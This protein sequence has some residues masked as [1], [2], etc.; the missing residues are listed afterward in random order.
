MEDIRKKQRFYLRLIG[1]TWIVFILAVIGLLL[2]PLSFDQKL[3]ILVVLV[4]VQLGIF[5]WISPRIFYYNQIYG[6]MRLKD[7][8]A[9]SIRTKQDL[10]GKSF[11][12]RLDAERFKPFKDYGSYVLFYRTTKDK[13]D[14]A[15]RRTMLEVITII[16]NDAI[17][18]DDAK[19]VSAVNDV[20]DMAM[21][22]KIRYKNHSIIQIKAGNYKDKKRI[23][24]A[25]QVVFETHK[26]HRISMINV[27]YDSAHDRAYF[28]HGKNYAPNAYYAYVVELCKTLA[29][30]A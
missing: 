11:Q 28:L 17:D 18:Y 14:L 21:K 13:R 20:E 16:K 4:I 7:D 3:S 30:P 19:L 29:K 12:K 2:T 25:D 5:L 10:V 27:I 15:T 22:A 26:G 24:K 23:E 1:L 6:F 9:P 8:A